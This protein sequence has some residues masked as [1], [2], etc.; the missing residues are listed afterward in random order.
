MYFVIND[1]DILLKRE[2]SFLRARAIAC[3]KSHNEKTYVTTKGIKLAAFWK[4]RPVALNYQ[5]RNENSD[6]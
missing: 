6:R 4:K 5:P 1:S 2:H 3:E